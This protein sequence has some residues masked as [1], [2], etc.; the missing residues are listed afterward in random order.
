M[1]RPKLLKS[2]HFCKDYTNLPDKNP[3]STR[4]YRDHLSLD[5]GLHV[6][7][8]ERIPTGSAIPNKNAE[9]YALDFENGL[10]VYQ[11]TQTIILQEMPERSKVGQLPRS[12]EVILEFDL[13]DKIK[14]GDRIQC[15]G[16]YRPKPSHANKDGETNSQFRSVVVAN[17]ISI[18]GKEIGAVHLTGTDVKHIR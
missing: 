12:I 13:A 10:S 7:G 3:Y 4:E 11:D 6:K 18:L 14:P 2:V 1:N 9:G 16:V 15:M 8:R 17:N 5:V